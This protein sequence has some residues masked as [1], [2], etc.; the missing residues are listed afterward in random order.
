[1]GPFA[2]A[3][4]SGLD[5]AWRNRQRLRAAGTLSEEPTVA[6]GLCRLSRFGVKSGSGW[7]RYEE[8]DRTPHPDPR[9]AELIEE[10][11]VRS[12]VRQRAFGT[13][14]IRWAALSAI[15]AEAADTVADGVADGAD[16]VDLV[17]LHGYGFPAYRGGPVHWARQQDRARIVEEAGLLGERTGRIVSLERLSTLLDGPGHRPA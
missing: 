10:A 13:E 7:Y 9:T 17:W 16:A 5:I 8:G 4:Q 1:M 15:L 2:V 12:G 3:D 14:E 6:D 11:A